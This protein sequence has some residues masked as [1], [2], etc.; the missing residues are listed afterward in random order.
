MKN[1]RGKG[2]GQGE[3]DNMR[4]GREIWRAIGERGM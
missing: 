2:R 1:K 3:S 4:K